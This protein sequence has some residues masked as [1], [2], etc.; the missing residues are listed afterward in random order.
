LSSGDSA[1]ALDRLLDLFPTLDTAEKNTVRTRL[2]DYF[3][4]LGTDAPLVVAARRRLT[5][6]LY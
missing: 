4:I 6:L 5:G 2:I 1:A 3:E